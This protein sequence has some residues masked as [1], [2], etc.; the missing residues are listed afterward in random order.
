D[1]LR[2]NRD[3]RE[4]YAKVKHTLAQNTWE[5]IQDYADAKTEIVEEIMERA[6]SNVM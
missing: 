3:D 2:T 6:N 1:W 4:K 5:N